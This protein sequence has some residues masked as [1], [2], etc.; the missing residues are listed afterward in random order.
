MK[1]LH[2]DL[3][4]GAAGDMLTAALISLL[5]EEEQKEFVATLNSI[6]M[7]KVN[8]ELTDD[9]KC[10]VTGKHVH[11]YVD[12]EETQVIEAG[13]MIMIS[14]PAGQHDVE[15]I[16]ITRG[17][18]LGVLAAICSALILIGIGGFGMY[19]KRSSGK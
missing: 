12:G 10:G 11:V 16:H 18:K 19:T 13:H 7:P 4:M 3:G 6:G 2:L 17:F 14:V 8:V 9:I 15:M 1:I 5:S